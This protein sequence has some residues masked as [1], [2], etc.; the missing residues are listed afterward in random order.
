LRDASLAVVVDLDREARPADPLGPAAQAASVLFSIFERYKILQSELFSSDDH[1]VKRAT[2]TPDTS[3]QQ[4]FRE[5]LERAEQLAKRSITLDP[6]DENA[7]FS[8]TLVYGPTMPLSSSIAILLL[9]ASL[10]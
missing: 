8:L 3:S 10:T 6:A 9:F 1:Y 4:Q 2:V 5:L 7:L